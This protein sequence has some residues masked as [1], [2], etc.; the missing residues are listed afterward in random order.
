MEHAGDGLG[1]G[2][3]GAAAGAVGTCMLPDPA[4]QQCKLYKY[5]LLLQV[6][7]SAPVAEGQQQVLTGLLSARVA[8]VE[9]LAEGLSNSNAH[10]SRSGRCCSVWLADPADRGALAQGGCRGGG[11]LTELRLLDQQV[12]DLSQSTGIVPAVE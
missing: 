2:G 10:A 5:L 6:T 11:G 9:A 4:K 12:L 3:W 8:R 1:A 7:G